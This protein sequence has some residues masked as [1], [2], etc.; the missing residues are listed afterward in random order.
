MTH[1]G[2]NP[3]FIICYINRAT[4]PVPVG[5]QDVIFM[6]EQGVDD[7]VIQAMLTPGSASSRAEIARAMPPRV[8]I[9]SDPWWPYY[10]PYCGAGIGFGHRFY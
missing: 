9:L 2:V 5:A 3:R 6:H 4:N 1:A 10:Y 7:Q 8:L